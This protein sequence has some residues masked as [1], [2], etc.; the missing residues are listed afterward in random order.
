MRWWDDLW[1]NEGFA[2]FVEDEFGANHVLDGWNMVITPP[3][4]TIHAALIDWLGFLQK[5]H[6]MRPHVIIT[7][8][9]EYRSCVKDIEAE[10]DEI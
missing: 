6:I 5:R 1:L 4:Y 10:I 2:I 3:V 7:R 9:R 8:L